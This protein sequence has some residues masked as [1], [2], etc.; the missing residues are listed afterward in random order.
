M[1]VAGC[2]AAIDPIGANPMRAL[3]VLLALVV[4]I[5][6]VMADAGDKI[7]GF[8]VER[9]CSSEATASANIQQTKAQCVQDEADAKK[10]LDQKWPS[11]GSDV[12]RKCVGE[13]SIG[14]DQSYVELLTCLQ[15]SSDWSADRTVG[16]APSDA[17]RH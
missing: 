1:L 10:R 14:G 3:F 13:S 7:P 8:D 15:M 17:P 2:A 4:A 5:P 6:R 9:N 16:R 12:K 11:L